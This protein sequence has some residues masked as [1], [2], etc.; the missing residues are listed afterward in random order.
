MLARLWKERKLRS[1]WRRSW[2]QEGDGV[3]TLRASSTDGMF[4]TA[5]VAQQPVVVARVGPH[6]SGRA[7]AAREFD[8]PN[9]GR[10]SQS[11][12]VQQKRSA[13]VGIHLCPSVNRQEA[14]VRGPPGAVLYILAESEDGLGPVR[15][16]RD[17]FAECFGACHRVQFISA[18]GI[19]GGMGLR[20]PAP[21][22][23]AVR[24]LEG[25]PS[26]RPLPENEPQYALGVPT[27][28]KKMSRQA[29][30]VWDELVGEMQYT[31]LLCHVDQRALWQLAEDEAILSEVYSGIWQM[32]AALEKKAREEKKKIPGGALFA[33]LNMTSGRLAMS[34]IRSL[35]NRVIIERREFGLTPSSRSR[36]ESNPDGARGIVDPLELKLCG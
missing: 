15:V 31:G 24:K 21:K 26:R 29:R 8:R 23:T 33:I 19:R 35:A 22:P 30:A 27:R 14:A 7:D 20:G 11:M 13:D 18:D 32:V 12:R 36:I 1:F 10:A 4:K 6:R 5:G 25:N 2:Q 3:E 16:K 17:A 28:P 9:N 34:A